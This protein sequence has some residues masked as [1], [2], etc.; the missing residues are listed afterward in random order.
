MADQ[1]KPL[2]RIKDKI[3]AKIEDAASLEVTTLTGDFRYTVSDFVAGDK[4]KFEIEKVLER[5]ALKTDIEL[6]LVAYTKVNFDGDANNIVK[7]NL[8][9]QDQELLRYHR[10]MIE[11]ST[12][13]RQAFIKMIT[14]LF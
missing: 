1:K 6:N 7:S 10:D 8:N 14:E 9:T 12:K 4:N 5:L 11:S 2:Q 3:S 13:S